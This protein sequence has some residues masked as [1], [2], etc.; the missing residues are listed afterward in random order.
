MCTGVQYSERPYSY[1]NEYEL[2]VAD[3]QDINFACTDHNPH[4]FYLH[5]MIVMSTQW[6]KHDLCEHSAGGGCERMP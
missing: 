4:Q 6:Q 5:T 3:F 1:A 2:H